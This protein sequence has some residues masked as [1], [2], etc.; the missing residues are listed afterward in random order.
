MEIRPIR[1]K[2]DWR[3]ATA[4]ASALI[5]AAAGSPECDE[6]A[7]LGLLIADYERRAFPTRAASVRDVIAFYMEQNGYVQSD[8]SELLGSRSRASEILS[9]RRKELSMDQIRKLKAGWRI[10][11]DLLIAS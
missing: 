2:A 4:R 1:T 3:Q 5:D 8:L 7:V 9:G 10:P 11:A 6:L